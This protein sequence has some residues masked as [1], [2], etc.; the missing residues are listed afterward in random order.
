[1][2]LISWAICEYKLGYS[3]LNTDPKSSK[4][5]AQKFRTAASVISF[6]ASLLESRRE[7][8]SDFDAETSHRCIICAQL[9]FTGKAQAMGLLTAMKKTDCS[10]LLL[11]RISFGVYELMNNSLASVDRSVNIRNDFLNKIALH[12]EI[13]SSLA[14]FFYAE[15][16]IST[17]KI[18]IS[19]G[20]LRLAKAKLQVQSGFFDPFSPGLPSNLPSNLATGIELLQL[21]IE[22]LLESTERENRLLYFQSIPEVAELPQFPQSAIVFKID[23]YCPPKF[24]TSVN[25]IFKPAETPKNIFESLISTLF[26]HA[27]SDTFVTTEP[28]LGPALVSQSVT[29]TPSIVPSVPECSYVQSDLE[30]ATALQKQYDNEI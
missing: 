27:K 19:L 15:S 22:R 2:A 25:F 16:L 11:S 13:F 20:F 9:Y 5:A 7:K 26:P 18:G 14:F 3:F 21:T 29:S 30:L 28:T 24:S 4:C 23:C 12:R 10:T 17:S 1:M 6:V 8:C